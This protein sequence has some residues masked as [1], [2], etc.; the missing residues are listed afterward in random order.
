MFSKW[1]V[2]FR[3]RK[4]YL[5]VIVPSIFWIGGWV[6]L[7]K[8]LRPG[9]E[10]KYTCISCIYLLGRAIRIRDSNTLW[11]DRTFCIRTW[12]LNYQRATKE[13]WDTTLRLH[14][15]NPPPRIS[16]QQIQNLRRLVFFLLINVQTSADHSG[17]PR[18]LRH[19]LSSLAQKLGSLVWI[20]L[21]AWMFVCAFNMCLCCP[22]CM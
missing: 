13:L 14:F 11:P 16:L 21:K 18:G 2:N 22:V 9:S 12:A 4:I 20:L 15:Y 3:P 19:E 10:S 17:R 6:G 8:E 5:G 1:V 7:R